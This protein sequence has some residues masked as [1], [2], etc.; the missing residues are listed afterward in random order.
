MSGVIDLGSGGMK[1]V[2]C[3]E[4][5]E[6][7][8]GQR[9]QRRGHSDSSQHRDLREGQYAKYQDRSRAAYDQAIDGASSLRQGPM[10]SVKEQGIVQPEADDQQNRC[11]VEE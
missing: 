4:R 1:C 11:D 8:T 9:S 2:L 10:S 6:E 7:Q 5:G 3:Q